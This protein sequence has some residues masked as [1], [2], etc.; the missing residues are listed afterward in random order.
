MSFLESFKQ[1]ID[2]LK[3]NK[4]RSILT[5]IGII[6]GVFSIVTIMAIGNAAEQ[7]INSM[8][9]KIGANVVYISYKN[10]NVDKN[11]WLKLEDM[12]IIKKA[13]P[14]IKNMATMIR[15]T[16][17]LRIDKE[18][19]NA[20]AYGVSSQ[21]KSFAPIEMAA[22][23]FINDFDVSSGSK[24]IIVDEFFAN[25]YYKKIDVVGEVLTFKT[26]WG[27]SINLK[28]IGVTK[29]GDDLFSGM[30]ANDTFPA[31]V[32]VPITTLQNIF[33]NNEML[34]NIYV[35]IEEKEGLKEIGQKIVRSLEMNKGKNDIYIAYSSQDEQQI[36]NTIIGVISGVLLIIAVI[37]LVVGGIGIVNILLVS[38]TE[39]IREIGVRK[40]LG[41]Q[42]RDILLQF[43][44]ESII[45][46]GISGLL[47][48]MLGVAAGNIISQAIKI[49]PVVDI[50][51]IISAFMG[52]VI[53]GLI[54]GVYPAKKA[55][56]LDPIEALRYE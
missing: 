36:F 1:A 52:S 11:E 45:M 7:Y 43:I 14:E 55:A 37:T 18:T 33:F 27:K 6:M 56:D 35:T 5:M 17:T 9:E 12:E 10:M 32:F 25:K 38:V 29:A 46:T 54:F 41:A 15:R 22:G 20:S 50:P 2:S 28:I 21:Y 16:G 40:A 47:G 4:L 24:V 34:D 23:R 44:T 8:F 51:V 19:R 13:V 26:S 53:L 48:I 30:A 31:E 3:A 39:R 42:K 49:P